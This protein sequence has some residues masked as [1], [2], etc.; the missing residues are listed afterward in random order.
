MTY[1]ANRYFDSIF[2]NSAIGIGGCDLD[3]CQCR[4]I[5][6]DGASGSDMMNNCQVPATPC[7][8]IGHALGQAMDGDT[9]LV[10]EETYTETLNI[11]IAVTLKGG[12]EATGWTQDISAN[13]TIVDGA[14]ANASVFNIAPSTVVTLE[15]FVVQGGN[16]ATEGGG[17]FING[18]NV[19]ISGTVVQDNT[20]GG[21]GGGIWV[22]G[23]MDPFDVMLKNSSLLTNTTSGEGGGLAGCCDGSG[24]IVKLNNVD[25]WA[26]TAR[27][28]G[29]GIS[30]RSVVVITNSQIVSNT[31]GSSAGGVQA[32]DLSIYNSEIS[33]NEANGTGSVF[34][35]GVRVLERLILQDSIVSNNQA[36]GTIEG[37][38]GGISA[39]MANVT[40]ADNS[41]RGVVG[42]GGIV[43]ITNSILWGNG[44]SDYDCTGNCT[45]TYSDVGIGDT[46][47]TVNVSIDP[48]FVG[49]GDY[50]IRSNSPVIDQGT[51]VGAPDKDFEGDP[52]PVD[53]DRDGVAIVDMGADEF[54]LKIYL[55]VVLKS[56]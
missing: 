43:T 46:T 35:G 37:I 2:D 38:G 44:T 4:Y 9:I 28:D 7:A 32:T 13:P 18:A 50:H 33:K 1:R 24:N 39:E 23:V 47:G 41:G 22:E 20:A 25:I 10:A 53:G 14:G 56:P 12:Y 40:V 49:G 31:A 51:N 6:V 11:G 26:N 54:S 27:G 42:I 30:L 55:P 21:S 29:G 45:L 8:T 34:G 52:R 15:G 48:L 17:F 16:P 36:I 3:L 5:Y 19:V